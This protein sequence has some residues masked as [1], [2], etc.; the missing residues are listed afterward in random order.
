MR[1]YNCKKTGQSGQTRM[2][3]IVTIYHSV[4]VTHHDW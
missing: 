2:E 3:W 1:I 4:A